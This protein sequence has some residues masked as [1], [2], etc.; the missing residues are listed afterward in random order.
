MKSLTKELWMNVPARRGI[1]SIHDEIEKLV[2][3]SGVQ[4]GLAAWHEKAAGNCAVEASRKE[5]R[6]GRVNEPAGPNASEP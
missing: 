1:V 4:D 2:R 6:L 5:A 3:E